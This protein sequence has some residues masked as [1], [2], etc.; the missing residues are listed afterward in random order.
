MPRL[1]HTQSDPLLLTP[2][3]V[4]RIAYH[5]EMIQANV[6]AFDD[7]TSLS[8]EEFLSFISSSRVLS[9]E[10]GDGVGLCSLVIASDVNVLGQMVLYDY[11]YRDYIGRD[12]CRKA[13]DLGFSRVTIFV[14][15]DRE[16]AREFAVRNGAVYE[17]RQRKAYKRGEAF[18]DVEIYALVKEKL[19]WLQQQ[20]LQLP[21]LAQQGR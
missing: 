2:L 18:V 8:L 15:R 14:S 4:G 7:Y 11:N 13:F 1:K 9:W 12:F 20:P 21:L 17:G 3:K 16:S 19:L 5:W 10:I 6:K